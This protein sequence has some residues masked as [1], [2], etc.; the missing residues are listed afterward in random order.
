MAAGADGDTS[1]AVISQASLP[2]E[3]I[4][5]TSLGQLAQATKPAKPNLMV[6]GAVTAVSPKNNK[7]ASLG[8]EEDSELQALL[9]QDS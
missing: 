3:H 9:L 5:R 6:I 8:M 7:S 1:C 4:E 2:Q